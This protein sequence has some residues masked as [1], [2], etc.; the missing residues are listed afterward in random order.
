VVY[1]D[2]VLAYAL[3]LLIVACS[4]Q[5]LQWHSSA[6]SVQVA[7]HAVRAQHTSVSVVWY[8]YTV[9]AYIVA[10]CSYSHVRRD[11]VNV[12]SYVIAGAWV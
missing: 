8:A 3:C 4:F 9:M 10:K 2:T 12:Y 6:R 1:Q 5:K 11:C 7:Y